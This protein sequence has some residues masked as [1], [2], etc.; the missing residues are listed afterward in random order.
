MASH[1]AESVQIQEKNENTQIVYL[2]KKKSNIPGSDIQTMTKA[3]RR[4]TYHL[5]IATFNKVNA[6]I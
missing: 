3:S 6:I 4:G 5:I 2:Q 1:I